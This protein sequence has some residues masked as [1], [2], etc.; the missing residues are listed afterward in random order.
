[1]KITNKMINKSVRFRGILVRTIWPKYTIN[2]FKFC[3]FCLENVV[4]KIPLTKKISKEDIYIERDDKTK[5]RC[6]L[7]Y[8]KELKGNLNK[9]L[10]TGLLWI[11]GGGYAIG[12]PEHD[13]MFL[14]N[15]VLNTNTVVL[16]PDYTKSLEKPFPAALDDCYLALKYL[17]DHSKE[18][19]V[20][21]NQIFVGGNSAGG[22]LTVSLSLLARD[23]KEVNI[24][25]VF[26]L[27]P[28]IDCNNTTTNNNNDAP[29]WNTYSNKLAW[30]LY[31]NTKERNNI[32][33]Y[34]SPSLETDY[35]NLPPAFTYIGTIDP[36]YEE[37]LTYVNK[38]KD[39]DI[40]VHVKEFEG[41]FHG[42]DIVGFDTKVG[43]EAATYLLDC[44]LYAV[45][46]FYK[47]N[48]RK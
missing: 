35:S 33:K 42:F 20:N 23:K 46:H 25:C 10:S 31:L 6:C 47:N 43:K 1:M 40:E 39:N 30:D 22:G 41:C 5:L 27:Y 38:L 9:I 45:K 15:F 29:V 36:F 4:K 37:T 3:N 18:Y 13:V 12:I 44:Y 16:A 8:K 7:Y 11:H 17:L 14:E 2:K 28:M 24:A 21:P 26:P 19:G 32:S 34:A 48:E